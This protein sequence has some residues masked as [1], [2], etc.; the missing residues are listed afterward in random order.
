MLN[1]I[2]M[3]SFT[4]GLFKSKKRL[5][6]EPSTGQHTALLPLGNRRHRETSNADKL[7][8]E[9]LRADAAALPKGKICCNSPAHEFVPDPGHNQKCQCGHRTCD[10]CSDA[11]FARP[12]Q[13]A[14]VPYVQ[15]Q[16]GTGWLHSCGAF[17]SGQRTPQ[18]CTR[19]GCG[20]VTVS[21][22]TIVVKIRSK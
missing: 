21:I 7:E 12:D 18:L 22:C 10:K 4:M 13:R 19:R 17:Y 8:R 1:R 20:D 15:N 5:P 6:A 16:D 2:V 11:V 9:R 3:V 14:A